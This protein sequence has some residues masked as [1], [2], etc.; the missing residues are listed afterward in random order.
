MII[1]ATTTLNCFVAFVFFMIMHQKSQIGGWKLEER[2][3]EKRR[4]R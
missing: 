1:D 2:K 3:R 4:K